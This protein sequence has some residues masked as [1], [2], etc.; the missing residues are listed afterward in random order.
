MIPDH[1][2]DEQADQRVHQEGFTNCLVTVTTGPVFNRT[3]VAHPFAGSSA[4]F[5]PNQQRK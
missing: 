4:A 5:A 2:E 3:T 1:H